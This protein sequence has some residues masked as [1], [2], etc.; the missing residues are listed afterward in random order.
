MP[1]ITPNREIWTR[2]NWVI[3]KHLLEKL[4]HGLSKKLTLISAPAGF[5]K[6][7]LIQQWLTKNKHTA[8]WLKLSNA[9]NDFFCFIQHI[10]QEVR[11]IISTACAITYSLNDVRKLPSNKTIITQLINELAQIEMPYV[12]IFD[13]YENIDADSSHDVLRTILDSAAHRVLPIVVLTRNDPPIH[14]GKLRIQ[15]QVNELRAP[16][17][18]FSLQETHVFFTKTLAQMLE[19]AEINVIYE[20]SEGWVA[21]LQL[22]QIE[23][24]NTIQREQFLK[25]FSGNTRVMRE[26]LL[27]QIWS[28]RSLE[29]QALLL[30][31]S[32]LERFCAAVCDAMLS[33]E[34][35]HYVRSRRV[36]DRLESTNA[37]IIPLDY[38]STWY[39]HH[40]L[41]RDFLRQRIQHQ[42][43]ANHV[44]ALHHKAGLWFL[45][46]GLADEAIDHFIVAQDFE[47]AAEVIEQHLHLYINTTN[48]SIRSVL[49]RWISRVPA[50]L[51]EKRPILLVRKA[52]N[53]Y[54]SSNYAAV[55]LI[56]GRAKAL[57]A[58][59]TTPLSVAEQTTLQ[60]DISALQMMLAFWKGDIHSA[61][62]EA[63]LALACMSINNRRMRCET[64]IYL[65]SLKSILGDVAGAKKLINDE[66]AQ[67]YD[68]DTKAARLLYVGL[69]NIALAEGDLSHLYAIGDKI[70]NLNNNASADNLSL[71]WSYYYRGL[72]CY[73]RNQLQAAAD[74][75]AKI[76]AFRYEANLQLYIVMSLVRALIL[77]IQSQQ[78]P[79]SDRHTLDHQVSQLIQNARMVAAEQD[80]NALLRTCAIFEARLAWARNDKR[81]AQ[82]QLQK[83]DWS[84]KENNTLFFANSKINKLYALVLQ[85]DDASGAEALQICSD[86]LQEKQTLRNHCHKLYS[87]AFRATILWRLGQL[88]EAIIARDIA[89]GL[90]QPSGYIR[91][92]VDMGQPMAH[93]LH[94][95]P[96]AREYDHFV[97]EIQKA[98]STEFT[99]NKC[100]SNIALQTLIAPLSDRELEVLKLL[101]QRLTRPE[102][103]TRLMISSNTAKTHIHNI[104]S[105]LGVDDYRAAIVKAREMGLV[106]GS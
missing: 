12:L 92:F 70:E 71:S 69:G 81:G 57:L 75:F 60:G 82:Q 61:L 90:A 37:L 66:L 99:A 32:L 44:K 5:G 36:I 47:R 64:L 63:D 26:Y 23:L 84:I 25:Q 106:D 1:I 33:D 88:N 7:T 16:D 68:K 45:N 27:E 83:I 52:Q 41:F 97:K 73:E 10:V 11:N 31:S 62:K 95:Y 96:V 15:G 9:D 42:W 21:G 40:N 58:T 24:N 49:S 91:V 72:V 14:L 50:S 102:I 87:Q 2:P 39:R 89:L 19:P 4:D 100:S 76:E 104:Y 6:S 13:D 20:R 17:L 53:E 67:V 65:A 59:L 105:K 103:A 48:E 77:L 55:S 74:F 86:S 80:H 56:L 78:N 22:C 3:R 18:Q 94:D 51:I 28:H 79:K 46:A 38:D 8:V 35:T 43:G 101:A 34:T 30:V 54:Y 29:M 93:L 85:E 98:L